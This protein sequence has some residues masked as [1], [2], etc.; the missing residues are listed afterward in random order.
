[1][2]HG[3][4]RDFLRATG[5]GVLGLCS[6][7]STFRADSRWTVELPGSPARA[8]AT[9]DTGFV[10]AS[11]LATEG[12][13]DHVRFSGDS[14]RLATLSRITTA[15]VLDGKRVLVEADG[16]IHEV[17][18]SQ[19][20]STS[21]G[22]AYLAFGR[23]SPVVSNARMYGIGYSEII[24]RYVVFSLDLDAGRVEWLR[25]YGNVRASVDTD[26]DRVFAGSPAGVVRAFDAAN[27]TPHWRWKTAGDALL[28]HHDGTLFVA[29]T[30]GLTALD[31]TDG[32]VR[33]HNE[34]NWIGA[35]GTIPEVNDSSVYAVLSFYSN[36]GRTRLAMETYLVAY[37]RKTG[38]ERWRT[39]VKFGTPI[40][41]TKNAVV[42]ESVE[43]VETTGSNA[44]RRERL[45][46]FGVGGARKQQFDLSGRL[47]MKPILHDDVVIVGDDNTI[48]AHDR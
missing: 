26:G 43:R 2:G 19:K 13:I 22:T 3:T 30:D 44:K 1:M 14:E 25:R 47:T 48:V 23:Y 12:G 46:I 9:T 10:V 16:I 34:S 20:K 33:W 39:R 29:S 42:A 31:P 40:S 32:A 37:N 8:S 24:G 6:G 27:G 4:R 7:C 15:P 5:V 45:S 17:P 36:R 38:E 41:V 28:T 11:T 35:V 21:L 18:L